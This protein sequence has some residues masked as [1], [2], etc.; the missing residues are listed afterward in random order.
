MKGEG[1]EKCANWL[2][3]EAVN[4]GQEER[5][6]MMKWSNAKQNGGRKGEVQ[7]QIANA[8]E[9]SFLNTIQVEK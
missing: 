7:W 5:R 9:K 4:D 2:E 6:R 1:Q 3:N 8:K